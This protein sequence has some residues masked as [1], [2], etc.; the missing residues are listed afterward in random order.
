MDGLPAGHVFAQQMTGDDEWALRV[1][2]NCVEVK[3]RLRS[4]RPYRPS[5]RGLI[6][7]FS[8]QSRMNLLRLIAKIDWNRVGKSLFITLTYPDRFHDRPLRSRTVDRSRW[9]RDTEKLLGR[10]YPL[11]WRCEWKARRSGSNVGEVYP[12]FHL[13]AF[14]VP[15]LD[16]RE[17]RNI[18]RA[19][20]EVEGPLATDVKAIEGPEGAGRYLAK[21]VSKACSL[22]DSTY[23]NNPWINGRS[24][25]LTRKEMVPMCSVAWNNLM[26][27]KMVREAQELAD[28]VIP[29]YKYGYRSG[30]TL[31]GEKRK[32]FF[33]EKLDLCPCK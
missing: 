16:H 7:K 25:G 32:N 14:G 6:S 2:G 29:F 8:R 12:H 30:F 9:Y 21:Y 18:W 23:L 15:F 20:L 19:I 22:D 26:S 31:L 5:P 13:L 4:P 17:V 27:P 1:Q 10:Q 28:H 33:M 24:W 11:L 3:R